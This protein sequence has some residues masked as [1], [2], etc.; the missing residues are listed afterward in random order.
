[1]FASIHL[2]QMSFAHMMSC[3]SCGLV[4]MLKWTQSSAICSAFLRFTCVD[5]VW[6]GRMEKCE[7]NLIHWNFLCLVSVWMWW[8]NSAPLCFPEIFTE[9][10]GCFIRTP[11]LAHR[12]RVHLPKWYCIRLLRTVEW[13]FCIECSNLVGIHWQRWPFQTFLVDNFGGDASACE[14]F[15]DFDVQTVARALATRFQIIFNI[16]WF[17]IRHFR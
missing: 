4:S 16:L 7:W 17:G 15:F 1:M 12:I 9:W 10:F 8:L 14:V 11:E 2:V 6:G 3:G 13:I 5:D